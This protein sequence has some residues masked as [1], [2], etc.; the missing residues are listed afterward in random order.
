MNKL[1]KMATVVV[2]VGAMLNFAG[3][4][5]N[6]AKLTP[7][8]ELAAAFASVDAAC[9]KFGAQP[10]VGTEMIAKAKAMPTEQATAELAKIK[11][12]VKLFKEYATELSDVNNMVSKAIG[13]P[14][15]ENGSDAYSKLEDFMHGDDAKRSEIVSAMKQSKMKGQEYLKLVSDLNALL[16]K[17]GGNAYDNDKIAEFFSSSAERQ[18]CEIAGIKEI[19]AGLKNR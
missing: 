12:T 16:K 13:K 7:Q 8:E 9:S 2:G 5:K 17:M 6:A 10:L 15:V 4:G 14:L 1:M 3:C 19:I 11:N 18:D